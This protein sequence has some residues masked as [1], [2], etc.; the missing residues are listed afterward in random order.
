MSR[1]V[2]REGL[3]QSLV[4]IVRNR[5]HRKVANRIKGVFVLRPVGTA[6]PKLALT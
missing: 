1:L 4:A 5:L 6:T 2:V 3:F